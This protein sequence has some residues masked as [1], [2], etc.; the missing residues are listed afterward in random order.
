MPPTIDPLKEVI[1][2]ISGK[3]SPIRKLLSVQKEIFER[4]Y[5]G[6]KEDVDVQFESLKAYPTKCVTDW[7]I[8]W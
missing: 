7:Q 3:K 1:K 5:V 4:Q 8:V 6:F 2:V